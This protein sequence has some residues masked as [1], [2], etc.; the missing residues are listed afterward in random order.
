MGDGVAKMETPAFMPGR[1]S[2]WASL[3]RFVIWPA[4]IRVQHSRGYHQ[5][6]MRAAGHDERSDRNAAR[7]SSEKSCSCFQAAK[8]P[9]LSTLL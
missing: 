9:P 6:W 4:R 7:I 3:N 8:W 2:I 5:C 1:T